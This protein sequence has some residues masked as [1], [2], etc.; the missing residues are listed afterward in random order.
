MSGCA[1]PLLR[2]CACQM[3]EL[4]QL[5]TGIVNGICMKAETRPQVRTTSRATSVCLA[6]NEKSPQ[7]RQNAKLG[8]GEKP[9][10]L[11]D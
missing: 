10:V 8:G 4:T 6:E 1:K 9:S 11:S 2:T 5:F 7:A 3:D